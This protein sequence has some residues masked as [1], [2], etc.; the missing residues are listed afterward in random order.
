M[1]E[2]ILGG[3]AATVGGGLILYY[4][5][6]IGRPQQK[7][8]TPKENERSVKTPEKRT[9]VKPARQKGA[10]SD[11]NI[12]ADKIKSTSPYLRKG[13]EDSYVG[14]EVDWDLTFT[15][16]DGREND[17]VGLTFQSKYT[18]PVV[19]CLAN[20]ADYPELKTTNTGTKMGVRGVIDKAERFHITLGEV[21]LDL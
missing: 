17:L 2:I 10:K 12:I 13:V 14:L 9:T 11:P 4:G 6:G 20:L 8:Q 16:I 21:K 15:D 19:S 7:T 5:F 3:L 1:V 18:Y